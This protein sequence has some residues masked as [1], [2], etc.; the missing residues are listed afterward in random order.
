MQLSIKQQ[1]EKLKKFQFSN[2][3]LMKYY[4]AFEFE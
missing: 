4:T 2:A 3:I 1:Y